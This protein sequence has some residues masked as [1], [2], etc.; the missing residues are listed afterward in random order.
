MKFQSGDILK[1]HLKDNGSFRISI[2]L[3][4]GS[5]QDQYNILQIVES[6]LSYSMVFLTPWY[7]EKEYDLLTSI[8]RGE[9]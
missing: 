3:V 1:D 6:K 2:R 7:I 8:F 5:Y 4:L 9:L